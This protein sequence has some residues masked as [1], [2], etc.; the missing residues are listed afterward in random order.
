[1]RVMSL[2]NNIPKKYKLTKK[3]KQKYEPDLSYTR[4]NH[5]IMP[6]V[7]LNQINNSSIPINDNPGGEDYL[8]FLC[9]AVFLVF[10]L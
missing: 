6:F 8:V 4:R 2:N 5:G 9:I 3:N 1:M 10:F 7:A